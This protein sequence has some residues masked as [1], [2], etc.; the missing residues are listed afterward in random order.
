MF[1]RTWRFKSSLAHQLNNRLYAG[2][3]VAQEDLK[4][5]VR[6]RGGEKALWAFARPETDFKLCLK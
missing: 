2:F 1:A 3:L 5:H 6:R 4:L